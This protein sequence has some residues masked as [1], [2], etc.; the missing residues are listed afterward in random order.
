MVLTGWALEKFPSLIVLL[1]LFVHGDLI[2]TSLKFSVVLF[3]SFIFALHGWI[4][5]CRY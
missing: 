4:R 1:W 3:C 5:E 2:S